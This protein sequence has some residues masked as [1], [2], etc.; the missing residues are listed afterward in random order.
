ML[1]GDLELHMG[2]VAVDRLYV[3]GLSLWLELC[4]PANKKA[5]YKSLC[6]FREL[7]QQPDVLALQVASQRQQTFLVPLMFNYIRDEFTKPS[8]SHNIVGLTYH[9]IK[10]KHSISGSATHSGM[11]ELTAERLI[12]NLR[13]GTGTSKIAD[14][15]K[16]AEDGAIINGSDAHVV[17]DGGGADQ[18]GFTCGTD[19]QTRIRPGEEHDKDETYVASSTHTHPVYL[20][21]LVELQTLLMEHTQRLTHF[22]PLPRT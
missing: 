17:S 12:I 5:H 2:E 18:F 16:V 11:P 10:I 21:R 6:G 13:Q 7:D 8:N 3:T 1:A 14:G 4:A 20:Q 15:A 9:T 22:N 19:M